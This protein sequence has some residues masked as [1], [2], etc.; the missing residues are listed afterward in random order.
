MFQSHE[1]E[2]SLPAHFLLLRV[3]VCLAIGVTNSAIILLEKHTH[4]HTHPWNRPSH[5]APTHT[6]THTRLLPIYTDTD[7]RLGFW[8]LCVHLHPSLFFLHE[9]KKNRGF[10]SCR[11][12]SRLQYILFFL[13]VDGWRKGVFFFF[14]QGEQERVCVCET[15]PQ[16]NRRHMCRKAHKPLKPIERLQIMGYF[17]L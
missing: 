15:R 3:I 16:H 7:T 5:I 10:I 8:C 2:V 4:T 17:F 9:Q 12:G 13:V 11:N 1:L 14:H 6:D